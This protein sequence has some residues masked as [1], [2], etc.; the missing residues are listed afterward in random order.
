MNIL[1]ESLSLCSAV[2]VVAAAAT[3]F[4]LI[5]RI[6]AA[7]SQTARALSKA[8][9]HVQNLEQELQRCRERLEQAERRSLPPG[10]Q[11][12]PPASIHLNRR[13]QVA[14]LYRRGETARSI[15]SALGISQGEVKLIIK[16]HHL[17]RPETAVTQ[18]RSLKWPRTRD[19]ASGANEGAA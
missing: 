8:I 4:R 9:E 14:Q 10:D 17:N 5:S 13:G 16:L 15:A 1:L 19:K 18:N 6:E 7:D 12:L 2:S 11:F 3:Y